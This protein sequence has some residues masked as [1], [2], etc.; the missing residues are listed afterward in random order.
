MLCYI[1]S[2]AKEHPHPLNAIETWVRRSLSHPHCV[3]LMII[4]ISSIANLISIIEYKIILGPCEM[5]PYLALAIILY[6]DG[7]AEEVSIK[8]RV[9]VINSN[10][11]GVHCAFIDVVATI[12]F[13]VDWVLTRSTHWGI[14]YIGWIHC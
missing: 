1:H 9:C 14:S 7:R 4:G 10:R 2:L 8:H 6:G 12:D 5:L 3:R 11:E 13:Y